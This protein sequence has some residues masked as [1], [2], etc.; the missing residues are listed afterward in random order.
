MDTQGGGLI[1]MGLTCYGNAVIQNLRH[2]SKLTWLLE[3]GKYD[4]LFKKDAKPPREKSQNLTKEFAKVIQFLGKCKKGQSVRPGN[5]WATLIPAVQDTLYEQFA[6]KTF[7]DSH[8]F[9]QLILETIHQSTIQDVDMKIVRPPPV[10][11]GDKL[12]HGA[13][14]AWQQTFSK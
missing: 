6:M 13:L 9:Y 10:T 12:I 8:E 11:Y 4:T 1:N 7:H 5:F 2:L 3:E 14:A